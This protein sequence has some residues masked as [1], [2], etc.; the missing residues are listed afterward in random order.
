[1]LGPD[2]AGNPVSEDYW[3]RN[4]SQ[5]KA[6]VKLTR[7]RYCEHAFCIASN[8]GPTSLNADEDEVSRR[9]RDH[10][11]N[12]LNCRSIVCRWVFVNHQMR[13]QIVHHRH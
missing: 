9:K 10:D 12:G 1:M 5:R 11:F 3:M 8:V 4:T 6:S 2:G 7:Q 13:R